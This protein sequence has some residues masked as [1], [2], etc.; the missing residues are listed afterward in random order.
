MNSTEPRLTWISVAIA[1][2]LVAC[3]TYPLMVFVPMPRL[4]TLL[5]AASF[6][7]ALA[8][9]SVG[10]S[11]ILALHRDSVGAEI[12]AISNVIAGALVTCMLIVQLQIRWTDADRGIVGEHS[13]TMVEWI[14]QVVLGLDVS[15]DVFVG[16]GTLLFGLAMLRDPLFGRLVGTL[17]ILVGGVV[18]LGFNLVAF[19]ELPVEAGLLDPGPIT[20]LWYLLVVLIV[21]LRRKRFTER[22]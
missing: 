18:I 4:A 10:L 7:P 17:G 8:F 19:P 14:W 22:L 2:G 11:R 3:I 16:I 5:V 15:F 21:I 12:A 20:G 6:G 13:E 9:A 1:L